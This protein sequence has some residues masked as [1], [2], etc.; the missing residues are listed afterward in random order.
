MHFISMLFNFIFSW[1]RIFLKKWSEIFE[2]GDHFFPAAA[3][4]HFA[5]LSCESL[6]FPP[7]VSFFYFFL[8]IISI[9]PA[10]SAQLLKALHAKYYCCMG[11]AAGTKC[12]SW[13]QLTWLVG[14]SS[15]PISKKG[16]ASPEPYERSKALPDTGSAAI[17]TSLTFASLYLSSCLLRKMTIDNSLCQALV[18]PGYL[19]NPVANVF[20][21][22]SL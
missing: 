4:Q 3:Q 13:E 8:W 17:S 5:L 20:V 2:I 11:Q 15:T 21:A 10:A 9:A 19:D 7:Y 22:K 1:E 6:A 18:I 14:S 16:N 12:T